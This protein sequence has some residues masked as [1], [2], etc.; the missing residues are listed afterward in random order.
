MIYYQRQLASKGGDSDADIYF[1]KNRGT[2]AC[3]VPDSFIYL[4]VK[5][6]LEIVTGC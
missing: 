3:R 5:Q 1:P 6:A 2:N 4:L